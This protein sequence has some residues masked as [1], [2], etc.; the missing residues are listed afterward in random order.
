[1]TTLH[2]IWSGIV[3]RERNLHAEFLNLRELVD[4][5]FENL[6][7][8][9]MLV[10]PLFSTLR[11]IKPIFTAP[12]LAAVSLYPDVKEVLSNSEAFSVVEIY[13]KKME[14]T[15]GVFVLG[16]ADT[17]QYKHEIGLMR[18]AMHPCDLDLIRQFVAETSQE[19]IEEAAPQGRLDAVGQLSRVVPTRLLKTY[20]GTPGP[21]EVT[22]M[23]WMRSIFR[24]IFLNLGNDPRMTEE[25]TRDAR[26]LTDYLNSL[27]AQ[28]KAEMASGQT[29][30]DDFL[31]RLL[32][33]QRDSPETIA[34][35]TIRRILGGT[36][37]GTV[38]THSKA[39]AHALDQLL[40]RPISLEEAQAVA[41]KD[42]DDQFAHYVFEALRFNPQNPFLIRH[43][44]KDTVIAQGTE[45]ETTIKEGSIVL[46]GTESAMFDPAVFPEPDAF[47]PTRP[48]ENY[49]HFGH[50][51]HTC[52]G[53]SIAEVLIPGVLKPLLKLEG[54]RRASN[55]ELD[56]DGAFPGKMIV[57][58]TPLS[59]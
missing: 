34:D 30:P 16:M 7:A 37:V 39:I 56:Y 28:R 4:L 57:E 43:C 47:H 20:F 15:T 25:A 22:M 49:L 32:F 8:K 6:L 33:L 19:I 35:E 58:F 53:K 26:L 48:L 45:R 11:H 13:A 59:E 21:D 41:R 10:R 38:D 27:I 5:R 40:N 46:V 29:L 52:F 3:G 44:E 17:P 55:E 51:Q 12:H 31:C 50:G 23:H 42:D 24:E 9:P 2:D 14:A 54:L 36:I 1:M 18:K